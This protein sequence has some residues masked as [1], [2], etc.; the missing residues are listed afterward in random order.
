MK[1]RSSN[2]SLDLLTRKNKTINPKN[3]DHRCFQYAFMLT[4]H[5]MKSNFI[6][7]WQQIL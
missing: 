6:S 2:K 4:Q 5:Y 1:K 3:I 7:S